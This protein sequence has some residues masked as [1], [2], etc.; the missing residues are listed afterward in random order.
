LVRVA[1]HSLSKFWLDSTAK[2]LPL[3][4]YMVAVFA[5]LKKV[6]VTNVAVKRSP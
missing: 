4:L 1:A 2:A 5:C 6:L 3:A